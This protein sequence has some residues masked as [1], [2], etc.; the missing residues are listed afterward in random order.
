MSRSLTTKAATKKIM[1]AWL[2]SANGWATGTVGVDVA[3]FTNDYVPAADDVAGDFTA[4][5]ISGAAAQVSVASG[6]VLIYPDGT[7]AITI[8]DL[9][10]F[11]PSVEPD[12]ATVAYGYFVKGHTN[13]LLLSAR[14]FD[15]PIQ[16]HDGESII[17]DVISP[18]PLVWQFADPA[19][20]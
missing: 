7:C 8:P 16:L 2:A 15:D 19:L 12:P 20:P 1:E 18:A 14:R 3:L 13:G 11:T 6:A 17:I 4:C 10:A 9:D 5:T